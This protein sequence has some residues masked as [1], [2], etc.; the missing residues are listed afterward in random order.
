LLFIVART[1]LP[2]DAPSTH[3]MTVF[4]ATSKFTDRTLVAKLMQQ[5]REELD[6]RP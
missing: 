5:Q 4:F 3:T 6:L 1:R 2:P